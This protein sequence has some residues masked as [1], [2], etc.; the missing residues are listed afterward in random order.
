MGRKGNKLGEAVTVSQWQSWDLN[1]PSTTVLHTPFLSAPLCNKYS[2]HTQ[3]Q[4]YL[5]HLA[6]AL[7]YEHLN[8]RTTRKGKQ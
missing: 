1:M 8:T 3:Q 4:N 7:D 6:L 5:S 2:G